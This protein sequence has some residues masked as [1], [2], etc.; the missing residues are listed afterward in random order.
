M[1]DLAASGGYY[2][3]A[4]ADKIFSEPTTI[5][6]SIGVFG[7]LPN[8]KNLADDLGINAEQVVTNKN[9]VTY[10][11]FEPLST[12]Q[13]DFIKE[14]VVDVYS[15]FTHRVA[16]GRKLTAEA[17]EAIAQG[18]VWTGTDALEI[19]HRIIKKKANVT[20]CLFLLKSL[21]L[22]QDDSVYTCK[23][24]ILNGFSIGAWFAASMP[25]L[26]Q[27]RVSNGSIT[28]SVQI[29]AAA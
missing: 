12:S 27:D 11:I 9:A 28:P 4:N 17:V 2:I 25:M 20:V 22:F 8:L 23:T 10:S 16:T 14:G 29:L 7:T 26:I 15:L 6:G 19:G 3:A 1:G 13:H 18:R 5:T 21:N 24:P